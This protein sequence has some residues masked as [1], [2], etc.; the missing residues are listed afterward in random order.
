VSGQIVGRMR[1]LTFDKCGK[2]K[3]VSAED[4]LLT[5]ITTEACTP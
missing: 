4:D 1:T 2:L 3:S 5:L